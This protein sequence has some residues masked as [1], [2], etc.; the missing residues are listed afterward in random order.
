MTWTDYPAE[1]NVFVVWDPQQR[2]YTTQWDETAESIWDGG[3]S[4][5]DGG[6][7][8]WDQESGNIKTTWIE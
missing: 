4:F 6:D 7:S 5:W 3:I 2:P 1:N 8:I